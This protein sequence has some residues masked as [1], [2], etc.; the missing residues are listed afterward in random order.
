M[1]YKK[2]KNKG[3]FSINLLYKFISFLCLYKNTIKSFQSLQY[4]EIKRTTEKV[5]EFSS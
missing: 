2:T 5:L 4:R 1:A 3:K